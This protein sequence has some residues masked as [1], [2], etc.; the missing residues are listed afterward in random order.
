MLRTNVLFTIVAI[1]IGCIVTAPVPAQSKSPLD[2]TWKANISRSQRDPNHL[3]ESVTLRF[4]VSEDAV[5]L[6]FTGVN[7]SG[8]QESG[9][10]KF[11]PDG[12]EYPVAEAPGIVEVSKWVGSNVL[13]TVAKK[14]G[15]VVGQSTYEVSGDGKTLTAKIKGIDESGSTFEQVI[16]FDRQ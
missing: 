14:D 8:E 16:V 2:G 10:R 1:L 7:M 15:K 3:F 5:S 9:T 12:K 4:E 6:T 11:H 13:E